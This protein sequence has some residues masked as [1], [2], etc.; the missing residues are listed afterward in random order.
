MSDLI[1]PDGR[2][3]PIDFGNVDNPTEQKPYRDDR[4]LPG[5]TTVPTWVLASIVLGPLAL[6]GSLVLLCLV[7]AAVAIAWVIYAGRPDGGE[8]SHRHCG[9]NGLPG[10]WP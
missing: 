5:D 3:E 7:A 2:R 4:I 1:G 9:L 8:A 6:T 10:P